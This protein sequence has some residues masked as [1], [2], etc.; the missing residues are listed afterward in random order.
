MDSRDA[1]PDH[2][3]VAD[4]ADAAARGDSDQV[5]ALVQQGADPN[6]TGEEGITPLQF[7]LLAQSQDGMRALLQAGANPNL[8]G[9]GGNTV[10][11]T[12]SMVDDPAYLRLLLDAGADPNARNA[13]TGMSA[14][15]VAAGPRTDAQFRMLLDAGADPD[16]ADAAGNTPLHSAAM[17]NAGTHVR[18]L[19]DKGAS[20]NARNAQGA[21][22]QT[23]F[24]RTPET[25]L[26]DALRADRKAIE[27]WL[28][29][30]GIPL[31]TAV[32]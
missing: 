28:L 1:F 6:G 24:F 14:L 9:M 5:R 2:A 12:A 16:L 26:S 4:L 19:L 27:Q 31:E 8:P 22:F 29:D 23:Y 13:R 30:H 15:A 11:H 7:A 3:L 18:L 21:S 25:R 10:V 32:Q 20:P 17:I